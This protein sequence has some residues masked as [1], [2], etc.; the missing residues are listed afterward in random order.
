LIRT[1]TPPPRVAELFRSPVKGLSGPS[2]DAD[3][4]TVENGLRGDRQF[5]IA[6]GRTC[7]DPFNPE[8]L[9]K[10]RFLMLRRITSLAGLRA[11]HDPVSSD[12]PL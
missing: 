11:C 5:A 10:G 2:A 3:Y 1:A 8:P 4:G 6:L 7:F 9:E 12:P